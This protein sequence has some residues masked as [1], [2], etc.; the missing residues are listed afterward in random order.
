M[1]EWNEHFSF[2][3]LSEINDFLPHVPFDMNQG[4]PEYSQVK[5]VHECLVLYKDLL[6]M[7]D[8]LTQRA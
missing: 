6:E 5:K 3:F 1:Y 4:K 7:G 2:S 8:H